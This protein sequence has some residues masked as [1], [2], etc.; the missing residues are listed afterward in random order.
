MT[1]VSRIVL[2][3]LC[4]AAMA[5]SG[6]ATTNALTPPASPEAMLVIGN[7]DMSEADSTLSR[8]D[9]ERLSPNP[10]TLEKK[11]KLSWKKDSYTFFSEHLP[12]GQYR[13]LG[14]GGWMGNIGMWYDL[15][16]DPRFARTLQKSRIN[17][18]GSYKVIKHMP[19]GRIGKITYEVVQ[20]KEPGEREALLRVQE[21]EMDPYWKLMVEKRLRELS[22]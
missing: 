19:P 5:V 13:F 11:F 4:A 6:C 15:K 8:V 17:F 9:V 1:P 22:K 18:I 14:Y 7:L 3:A 2:L 16:S 12:P 10:D 20:V 21:W